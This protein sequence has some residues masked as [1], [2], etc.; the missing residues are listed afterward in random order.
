VFRLSG[1]VAALAWVAGCAS[2]P[3]PHDGPVSAW[4]LGPALPRKALE[5]GVAAFGQD[6]V[7]AGGFDTGASEGLD[8]TARVDAFDT[9]TGKWDRLPDAP[10]RWIDIDLAAVGATLY[11]L[12]GLEGTQRT[13]HGEAYALDP[14]SQTWQAIAAMDAAGIHRAAQIKKGGA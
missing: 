4:S 12:G 7:V 10:V 6:V 13:A 8:I 5:P 9:T 3:S 1:F 11:L 2:N 14:V